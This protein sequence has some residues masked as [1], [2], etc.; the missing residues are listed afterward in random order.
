MGTAASAKTLA[1]SIGDKRP[2]INKTHLVIHLYF[3]SIHPKDLTRGV[4]DATIV[5][6]VSD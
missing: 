6:T 5:L 4:R 2:S 1:E 3:V